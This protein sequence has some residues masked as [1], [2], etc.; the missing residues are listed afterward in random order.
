MNDF[1]QDDMR[2]LI[3]DDENLQR[4]IL[5]IAIPWEEHGFAVCGEARDGAQALELCRSLKPD[6]ILVDV[7][8]PVLN[9]LNLIE[10]LKEE[11]AACRA[12]IISGHDEFAYAR[13][14]I[15]LGVEDYLL[16]P[17]DEDELLSLML[18]IRSEILE[19]KQADHSLLQLRHQTEEDYRSLRSAFLRKVA[20]RVLAEDEILSQTEYFTL[21]RVRSVAAA[22]I[23]IERQDGNGESGGELSAFRIAVAN[24]LTELFQTEQECILFDDRP[25]RFGVALV[26]AQ[27]EAD[28]ASIIERFHA[29]QQYLQNEMRIGVSIGIGDSV[30]RMSEFACSYEHANEARKHGKVFHNSRVSRYEKHIDEPVCF[31]LTTAQRTEFK[32][33]MKTGNQNAVYEQIKGILCENA[34]QRAN[35]KSLQNTVFSFIS[36]MN[37]AVHEYRREVDFLT[38][39]YQEMAHKF[40]G[41]HSTGEMADWLCQ[42]AS[43]CIAEIGACCGISAHIEK[44]KQIILEQYGNCDLRLEQIAREVYLNENYLSTKF[45]QTTGMSIVEYLTFV[46]LNKAKELLDAHTLSA[47]EVA[48]KVGYL[49]PNYFSKCFKKEFGI[50]PHQYLQL[51]S[52][53]K[54]K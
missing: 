39:S 9:G 1:K 47:A 37:E 31:T 12:V 23:Q 24:V 52:R 16:K 11:G 50:S 45:A 29:A 18:R 35:L 22:V 30:Q 42:L 8:M 15:T 5:K 2:V 4:E 41:F 48:E 40:D 25:D 7:N 49:D 6:I 17:I 38:F 36:A 20:H 51:N 34:L 3:V 33:N 21:N 28:E 53:T 43:Q 19:K 44:A 46:R 14:A 26:T 10:K 27:G 13:R 54:P 32:L